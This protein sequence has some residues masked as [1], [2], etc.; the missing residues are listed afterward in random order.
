MGDSWT[1]PT[2]PSPT[3]ILGDNP[4]FDF[5]LAK[6]LNT[7]YY[8]HYKDPFRSEDNNAVVLPPVQSVTKNRIEAS[9]V[10]FTFGTIPIREHAGLRHQSITITGRSGLAHRLGSKG[11]AQGDIF[12]AGPK[13]FRELE[14][15][16]ELYQ[17]RSTK[18]QGLHRSHKS[19]FYGK[20]ILELHL[21][22]EQKHYLVEPVRFEWRK[23]V[24]SARHTY[25]WTMEFKTYGD[26]EVPVP[27]LLGQIQDKI[28][29]IGD[30]IDSVTAYPEKLAQVLQD[31][32]GALKSTFVIV[33]ALGRLAG[34]VGSVLSATAG[35]M[36]FPKNLVNHITNTAETATQ[37]IYNAYY[38][39]EG[40]VGE[41]DDRSELI[42]VLE[43]IHDIRNETL[44]TLG[45]LNSNL[46]VS[47]E[48][49]KAQIG[50]NQKLGKF[51]INTL[52]TSFDSVSPADYRRFAV[53]VLEP[54]DFSFYEH[55]LSGAEPISGLGPIAEKFYGDASNW[56]IIAQAN[57]MLDQYTLPNGSPL[58]AGVTL[59]I[60]KFP[61]IALPSG[62]TTED[63]GVDLMLG[64]DGDLVILDTDKTELS[65]ISGTPNLKQALKV[66]LLT[67]EGQSGMFP[68]YGLPKFVAEKSSAFMVGM[69]SGSVRTQVMAD[70][71]ISELDEVVVVDVGDRLIVECR[72]HAVGSKPIDI[73]APLAT[74][75]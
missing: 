57:G 15:F 8:L 25:A 4:L 56:S 5:S 1:I 52:Q 23:D 50:Y 35:V 53:P 20:P 14:T 45:V 67:T 10:D 11:T 60:P 37:K 65:T 59:Q 29:Q 9:S 41:F 47:A 51:V 26:A 54:A 74:L 24:N 46:I 70:P 18:A 22:Q 72:A 61:G 64:P 36:N 42:S 27:N 30:L 38:Q 19:Q 44:K 62:A 33:S 6:S 48:D 68:N 34:S 7:K 73:A 16:L 3:G 75:L 31:V 17:S 55:V 28:N 40:A 71:R 63:Y 66:R 49:P 21:V 39:I 13:L 43:S 32:E 69:A 58:T 12:G 2:L